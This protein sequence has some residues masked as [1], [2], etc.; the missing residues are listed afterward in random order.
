MSFYPS[1][2]FTDNATLTLHFRKVCMC[3]HQ[4]KVVLFDDKGTLIFSLYAIFLVRLYHVSSISFRHTSGSEPP[5]YLC[6]T[7]W[8]LT[9]QDWFLEM[10]IIACIVCRLFLFIQNTSNMAYFTAWITCSLFQ[11]WPQHYLQYIL[12]RVKLLRAL[13]TSFLG[14]K[15]LVNAPIPKRKLP[16]QR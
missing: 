13:F 15:W 10:N 16:L 12:L 11:R 3:F 2:S 5:F 8:S 14:V 6:N 4:T 7:Q 1:F 9:L